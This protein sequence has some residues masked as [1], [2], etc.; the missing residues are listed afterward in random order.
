MRRL[1]D[2]ESVP[3]RQLDE[4]RAALGRKADARQILRSGML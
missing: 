2:H 1:D 4:R 3:A